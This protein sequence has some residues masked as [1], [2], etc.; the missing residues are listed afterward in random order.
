MKL[1]AVLSVI[2]S[3]T[4]LSS[5]HAAVDYS[6]CPK[7]DTIPAGYYDPSITLTMVMDQFRDHLEA[8]DEI[9]TN[10]TSGIAVSDADLQGAADNVESARN[11]A[12]LAA[13]NGKTTMQPDK[14]ATLSGADQAAFLDQ[15]VQ[16]MTQLSGLM[17]QYEGD[18]T[19]L[20]AEPAASR[21]FSQAQNDSM[22][23]RDFEDQGHA[24]F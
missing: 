19:T 1:L 8:A 18:F 2:A 11:C 16:A 12:L 10:G 13:R 23:V 9:T 24:K 20:L 17:G 4:L 6:V 7:V 3:L 14:A 5:A 21:N 22:T 15:F